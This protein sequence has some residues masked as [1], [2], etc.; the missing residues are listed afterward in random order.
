MLQTHTPIKIART[1]SDWL[2]WL[3]GLML[4]GSAV[5]VTVDVFLR[6]FFNFSFGGTDEISGYAFAI[7][8]SLSLSAA[9]LRR[10]HVRVDVLYIKFPMGL[11]LF[12]DFFGL[13]LLVGFG[14]VV[15]FT[16]WQLVADTIM[17]NSHSITPLRVPLMLPQIPWLIGWLFF[18]VCGCLVFVV[19]LVH[20]I[21]GDKKSA[22]EMVGIK[23]GQTENL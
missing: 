8:T 4:I 6:K 12:C 20:L 17:H 16:A 11:R 1:L 5:L 21:Q 9:L 18:V 3:G 15:A 2:V 22:Q 19:A 23:S 7:A 14:A 10:A 13:A